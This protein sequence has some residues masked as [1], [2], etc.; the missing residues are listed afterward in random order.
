MVSQP[1]D[2][3]SMAMAKEQR[4]TRA[5]LLTRFFAARVG[6]SAEGPG[7]EPFDRVKRSLRFMPASSPSWSPVQRFSPTATT[8][9][10]VRYGQTSERPL[11]FRLSTEQKTVPCAELLLCHWILKVED[12]L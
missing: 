11:A 2:R 5:K 12:A 6:L 7:E 10:A 1:C 9:P 4:T 8:H 3:L